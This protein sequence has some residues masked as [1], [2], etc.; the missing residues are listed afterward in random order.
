MIEKL[1]NQATGG[2][3]AW[4]TEDSLNNIIHLQRRFIWILLIICL[5]VWGGWMSV[6]LRQTVYLPP[7]LSNG[8]VVKPGVIPLSTVYSFAYEAWQEINYW[9]NEGEKDYS[10]NLDTYRFYLTQAFSD[11]LKQENED[12]KGQGQLDRTRDLQGLQGAA[13]DASSVKAIGTDTWEVDLK[14]RLTEYKNG[15]VVK[16]V[17]ILYPIKVTSTKTSTKYNPWGLVLSGF[18]SDPQRIKTYV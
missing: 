10:Q 17:E 8:A 4:K 5:F 18:V 9:P 7:D 11:Q 14:M 15:Q 1:L 6:P 16:D 2:S 3:R 12:L 13:F